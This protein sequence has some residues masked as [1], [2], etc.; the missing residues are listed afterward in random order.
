MDQETFD[1]LPGPVALVVDDEPLILMD[2]SDMM[3]D[4]GYHVI[5]AR[6][7]DDAFE[8]LKQHSSLKVVLTDIQM[9]G[10]ID[11]IKLA[12]HIADRWPAIKVIVASG[13]VS[14][15]PGILPESATFLN[16]PISLEVVHQAL[17]GYFGKTLG[18]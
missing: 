4:V 12:H 15:E 13:A 6:N 7:A 2:T 10:E 16:K 8:F 11:G 5:E 9:P 14:P 17:Q 3:S 1:A 18:V